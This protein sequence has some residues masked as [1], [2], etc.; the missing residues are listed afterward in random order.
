MSI[1]KALATLVPRNGDLSIEVG[2]K[3][4]V[5]RENDNK[6]VGPYLVIQV[7]GKQVFVILKNKEVKHSIHQLIPVSTYDDIVNAE[8]LA[9]TFPNTLPEFKSTRKSC[10]DHK[11]KSIH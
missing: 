2:G 6:Y 10:K 4:N 11:Q 7:D 9:T 8:N 5:F 1:R 3:V